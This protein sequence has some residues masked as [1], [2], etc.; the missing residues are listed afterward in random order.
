[1][2]YVRSIKFFFSHKCSISLTLTAESN[3]EVF[4]LVGRL[5]DRTFNSARHGIFHVFL[6][7][8]SSATTYNSIIKINFSTYNSI[9]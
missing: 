1:M 8:R 2:G 7:T 9:I 3:R 6:I 4:P 5:V